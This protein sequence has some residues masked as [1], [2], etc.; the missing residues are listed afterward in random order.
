MQGSILTFKATC[1]VGQVRL[2]IYLS[3]MKWHLSTQLYMLLSSDYWPVLSDKCHYNTTCPRSNFS[4]FLPVR[5]GR[6]KLKVEPWNDAQVLKQHRRGALLFFKVIHQI[7]RSHGT[8]KTLIL[9][10]I[11]RF[12]TLTLVFDLPMALKWCTKLEV[13]WKRCPIVFQGHPS[14]FKV[15]W[16]KKKRWFWP[17]LSVSRPWL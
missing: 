8:K 2:K 12:Q 7:S 11:E 17:E 16:D 6:T 1:P 4:K 15:T 10:R 14:D 5:D 13:A 3:C 9:T